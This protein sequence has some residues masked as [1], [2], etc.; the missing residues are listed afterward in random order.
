VLNKTREGLSM[1]FFD[2][3]NSYIKARNSIGRE[4]I[5][6]SVV[7]KIQDTFTEKELFQ[8]DNKYIG[9]DAILHGYAQ[10]YSLDEIKTE[11]STF[12]TL[13]KYALCK[14]KD[15]TKIVFLFPFESYFTEK[16]QIIEMFSRNM[17][18]EYKI[19]NTTYTHRFRP[20]LIKS[21]PQGY[22]AGMDYF[23]D[24]KGKIKEEIPNITLIIDIGMGTCNLIYLLRGEIVR[25]MS[26]TT[27]NGMH[28]IYKR[29]LN[30]RK[31]YEVDL[32]NGYDSVAP[33]Y[34][35]LATLIKSDIST[36]YEIKKIDKI[37]VVGGGGTAIYNFLPWTN[38]VSHKG[39]MTNIRGAEKVVKNLSWGN[40]EHSGM[41]MS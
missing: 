10:D 3:G 36:Y 2:C 9:E 24:D 7:G 23:L 21:L 20:T 32:Y 40:L 31:I 15:E 18:I 14:Y 27:K 35:D 16:K 22:S 41:I 13:T 12:K 38:K 5:N 37:V 1:L 11:Q 30:G 39:Q 28:Q 25:E 34:D 6:L 26:H 17:D 4:L 8:I 19:G 33:L 29:A